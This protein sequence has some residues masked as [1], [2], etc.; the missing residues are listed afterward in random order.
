MKLP[1][2]AVRILHFKHNDTWYQITEEGDKYALYR[3]ESPDTEKWWEKK[4]FALL[5][6][7]KSLPKLEE[8]VYEGKY[9]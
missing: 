4:E 9:K 2:K 1:K 6:T 3:C 5:A 8:R 7:G